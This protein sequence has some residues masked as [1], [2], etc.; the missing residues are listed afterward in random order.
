MIAHTKDIEFWAARTQLHNEDKEQRYPGHYRVHGFDLQRGKQVL[1]Y[2]CGNGF[3]ALALAK[4]GAEVWCAD[5]VASNVERTIIRLR[6]AGFDTA[7]PLPLAPHGALDSL[8]DAAIDTI[9][10]HGVLHHVSDPLPILVEFRRVVK[11]AGDLYVMLYTEHYWRRSTV[12]RERLMRSGLNR[13]EAFGTI[14]D[15]VGCAFARAYTILE[16]NALLAAGGFDVVTTSEYN[17]GDFR[18]YHAKPTR[19]AQALAAGHVFNL[20]RWTNEDAW[21]NND[22]DHNA[23]VREIGKRL[24]AD[25]WADYDP[26]TCSVNTSYGYY[27]FDAALTPV[28]VSDTRTERELTTMANIGVRIA[29]VGTRAQTVSP[30]LK[31]VWIAAP[32]TEAEYDLYVAGIEIWSCEPVDVRLAHEHLAHMPTTS[33]I[34]YDAP[35]D[36]S[37]GERVAWMRRLA[38]RDADFY[39]FRYPYWLTADLLAEFVTLFKNR[40]VV[41]WSSE[42]GP[43][44][45]G[46]MRH[47]TP[48]RHVAANNYYDVHFFR[49]QLSRE[50]VVHYLPF[51]A[52]P[53]TRIA[54]PDTRWTSDIIADGT[55]H[56]GCGAACQAAFDVRNVKQQ[57]IEIMIR[58]LLVSCDV[59]LWGNDDPVHG[60]R[61]IP[62]VQQRP[63]LYRGK[64]PPDRYA[65]VYASCKLYVGASW[66]WAHGGYGTKLARALMAGI[67]VLWHKTPGMETDGLRPHEHL[68]VSDSAE[69]TALL[70]STSAAVRKQVGDAG[71]A[72]AEQNW[73]WKPNLQRLYEEL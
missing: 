59:G 46:V 8:T 14:T 16:G 70:M 60:W 42:Q 64:Y 23:Q 38:A 2:G 12:E 66:N 63:T 40:P 65:D 50:T 41:A 22:A 45:H 11:D 34:F 69:T 71:R 58:P 72:F 49:T 39:V 55:P 7:R 10:C 5:V 21:R 9:N 1:E 27:R 35:R 25:A 30:P 18:V 44:R 53:L 17:H 62:E 19:R 15:G 56:Y 73:S 68:L 52:T 13:H 6:A 3:D 54:Q 61:G 37:H 36:V 57:S 26:E 47:F 28:R 31:V 51:C 24:F 67:P 29:C 48:F 20:T 32:Q 43:M 4:Y 33:S